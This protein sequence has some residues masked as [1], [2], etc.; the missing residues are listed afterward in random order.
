MM[1][2]NYVYSRISTCC[3]GVALGLAKGLGML[4][5]AW[6]AWNWGYSVDMVNSIGTIFHG[7]APTLMGGFYGF[8]WGFLCGFIAGILIAM[9]YNM[10]LRCCHKKV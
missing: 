9:F 4:I 2:D 8:G 1:N 7:Y 6:V 10:C 3:L 5:F